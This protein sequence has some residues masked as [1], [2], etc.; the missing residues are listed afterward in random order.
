MSIKWVRCSYHNL[1]HIASEK[2]S[3]Y[4]MTATATGRASICQVVASLCPVA[5][6]EG[7]ETLYIYMK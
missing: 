2:P 1:Q 3:E 5:A 7:A 6:V 4:L